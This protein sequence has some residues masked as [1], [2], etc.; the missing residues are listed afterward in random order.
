MSYSIYIVFYFLQSDLVSPPNITCT[1]TV[2]CSSWKIDFL[3][4]PLTIH[5]FTICLQPLKCATLRLISY[6]K[7]CCVMNNPVKPHWFAEREENSQEELTHRLFSEEDKEI[8]TLHCN[9]APLS[10]LW[11]IPVYLHVILF[12]V[13]PC[14]NFGFNSWLEDLSLACSGAAGRG[15]AESTQ[16]LFPNFRS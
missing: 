15:W 8:H 6:I 12:A 3:L 10:C 4:K 14:Y 16:E 7:Y 2:K 11:A 1:Q 5:H 9:S 13:L